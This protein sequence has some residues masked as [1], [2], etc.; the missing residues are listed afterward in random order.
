MFLFGLGINKNIVNEEFR[1][2][3]LEIVPQGYLAS[4]TATPTL[5]EKIR[6]A[7]LHDPSI[8]KIKENIIL[9]TPKYM[10]FSLDNKGTVLFEGRIVVPK[11]E[12]LR[13]L[14]LKEASDTPL[15]IHSGSTKMYQD[16]KQ[17]Y[18]WTRMKC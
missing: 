11:L 14:I 10:C 12:S 13:E 5:E 7:Q 2:L 16:L 8:K 9:G 4:L 3:N 6:D 1:K 15:S 17:V 18:W